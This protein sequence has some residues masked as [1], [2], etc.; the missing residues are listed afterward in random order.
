[1]GS[2][3]YREPENAEPEI[4]QEKPERKQRNNPV[5]KGVQSVLDGNVLA[6]DSVLKGIPFVFYA[7]LLIVFYIANTYYAEKKIIE[8]EKIKRELKEL[9]SENITSKSK[10]M[11]YSRQSEVI[12]RIEP[13]GIKESLIPPRKIFVEPDTAAK[14]TANN[15]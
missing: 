1:M 13:Y 3:T 8:I 5:L 2:N 9:R 10:L 6:R 14:V 15:D 11:Y 12:K 4:K 7:A